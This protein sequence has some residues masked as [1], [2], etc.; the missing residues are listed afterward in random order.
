MIDLKNI[1]KRYGDVVVLEHTSYTFPAR[2]L[3]C[4]MGASGSGKTTLFNLIAGFDRRYEGEIITLGNSITAMDSDALCQYRK[5]YIGFVF[6]NYHLLP[7]YSV[8]ENV[9]LAAELSDESE[10]QSKKNAEALLYRLGIEEKKGQKIENLSGGQKQRVAIARALMGNPRI[11]LADEPT[12]ALDRTTSTEIMV[13][14][15]ELAEE[16]LVIVIT[17]DAKLCEFADEIIYIKN[18]KI[19]S[20]HRPHAPYEEGSIIS[21]TNDKGFPLRHAIQNF[22]VH[23]KRYLIVAAAISIGMLSFLFSLSF[24][25][26]MEQSIDEFE[27]K[28]T[29]FNNSYIKG[30][31]GGDVLRLL[32]EDDRIE[33]AY[34]QYKLGEVSLTLDGHTERLP[35]KLPLPKASEALSYGTMPRREK[36]EITLTPSLAKKFAADIKTLLG[37]ELTLTLDAQDYSLT[38]SGIYNAG[39]DDFFVSSDVEQDFYSQM[40]RQENYS[41]S[42]DV[43][44][45]DDIVAVSNALK[46]CGIASIDASNEVFNLQETFRSLNRLFLILSVLIL[47]IAL[48]LCAALLVKLQNSRYREMGLLS[49]LGFHKNYLRGMIKRENILLAAFSAGVNGLL[50][51]LGMI[52]CQVLRVPLLIGPMQFLS[53]TIATFLIIITISGLAAFTLIRTETAEALRK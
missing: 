37:K 52:S 49:A 28:N 16:R 30:A 46:L 44:K 3:V 9:M 27:Q 34:Y 15:K 45:F 42:Y 32:K 20:D 41:I 11:I 4:L 7:G 14:L 18:R 31:D 29:A 50:L 1:T 22:R 19:V 48:F 10:E 25:N 51:G 43:K 23:L 33:N 24:V 17:H 12:G 26:V 38:V 13:L 8:L 6:Q 35:E 36:N 47:I 21:Y 40:E 53:C 5:D 39:Y 2:G